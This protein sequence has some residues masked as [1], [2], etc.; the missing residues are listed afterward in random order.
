[1]IASALVA[2]HQLCALHYGESD[3]DHF[4]VRVTAVAYA[5]VPAKEFVQ[6]HPNRQYHELERNIL[7]GGGFQL[8]HW[9]IEDME[10]HSLD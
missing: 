10:R 6:L 3:D 2:N 9:R 8:K 4:Y 1:M 7:A 5:V